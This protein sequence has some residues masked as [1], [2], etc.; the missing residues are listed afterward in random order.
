MDWI[1]FSLGPSSA[2]QS[3][4]MKSIILLSLFTFVT[5]QST[6]ILLPRL[7]DEAHNTATDITKKIDTFKCVVA[8]MDW[9]ASPNF[10]TIAKANHD[11]VIRA[12]KVVQVLKDPTQERGCVKRDEGKLQCSTT[13]EPQ[14]V[15]PITKTELPLAPVHIF[16]KYHTINHNVDRFVG[17]LSSTINST[18]TIFL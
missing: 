12:K 7:K 5:A 15:D 17:S 14:V 1:R 16:F 9:L 4:N 10:K 13:Y 2:R 11:I 6:L 18:R 3:F 8:D